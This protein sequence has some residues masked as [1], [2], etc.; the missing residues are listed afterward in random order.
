MIS[1]VK[2]ASK[3]SALRT[4]AAFAAIMAGTTL[5]ASANPLGVW[6]D[7]TGRGAVQISDC[8]GKLCGRVVWVKDGK[9][10]QAC[11]M[12]I[13]GNARQISAGKWDKGWIYDPDRNEKFDVEL[14]DMGERLR[15]M[16]Y[17]GSKFLSEVMVW[18]RAPA[19]LPTCKA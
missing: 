7:H 15:V 9:N 6:I 14:T 12:Q 17:A 11:G 3:R 19:G 16:G 18:K 1:F 2:S 4:A 5:A 10:A 13:I 8:G